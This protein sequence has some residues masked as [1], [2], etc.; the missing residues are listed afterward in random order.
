MELF[1]HQRA[2]E[3]GFIKVDPDKTV[4]EIAVECLG[5]GGLV[6]LEDGNEPL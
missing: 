6:W 1:L 5:E 2:T 4:Q 3:T